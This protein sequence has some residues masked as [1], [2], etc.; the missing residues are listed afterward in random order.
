M[1][2]SYRTAILVAFDVITINEP[3]SL[4]PLPQLRSEKDEEPKPIQIEELKAVPKEES[5]IPVLDEPSLKPKTPKETPLISD[6]L[7]GSISSKM[8]KYECTKI[9]EQETKC[10]IVYDDKYEPITPITPSSNYSVAELKRYA[11]DLI[12]QDRKAF[13]VQPVLLG[14][15]AS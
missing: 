8:S 14:N 9:S 2:C 10:E 4:F 12:N 7:K 5:L 1:F 15:K 13:N 3:P 6:E 11:F